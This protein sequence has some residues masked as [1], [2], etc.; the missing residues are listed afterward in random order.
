MALTYNVYR[1]STKVAEGIT[2][3]SYQDTGLTPNTAYSYQVSAVNE[4]GEESELSASLSVTTDYSPVTSVSLDKTTLDLD[5]GS[6]GQLTATV[7]PS[8]AN[9]QVTWIS[10]DEAIATVDNN[11]LVT[12]VAEGTAN[13]VATSVEDGTKT[14]SCAVTVTNPVPEA[15]E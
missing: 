2:E 11:G 6:T 13:I 4:Y 9:Q 15:P 3:T 7:N 12:A 8:T 10:D 14:A 5:T 1:D